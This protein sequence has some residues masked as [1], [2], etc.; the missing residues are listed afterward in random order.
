MAPRPNPVI[1]PGNVHLDVAPTK[2]FTGRAG[3]QRIRGADRNEPDKIR[4]AFS[5][6]AVDAIILAADIQVGL[7]A[8]SDR[9]LC[10]LQLM[11][12]VTPK[13]ME[14]VYV[15]IKGG[16]TRVIWANDILDKLFLDGHSQK[17][18]LVHNNAPWM[19]QPGAANRAELF[20][21]NT[22]DGHFKNTALDTPGGSDPSWVV[23]SHPDPLFNGEK[24][25]MW[26]ITRRDEFM[27][28]AVFIH[29]SG[30]R[31]PIALA[32]W[33]SSHSYRF[34]WRKPKNG[35]ESPDVRFGR[36]AITMSGPVT[37]N[38]ADLAPHVAKIKS[39][40]DWIHNHANPQLIDLFAAFGAKSTQRSSSPLD[41]PD[42]EADFFVVEN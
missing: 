20:A 13:E 40:P 41:P 42:L 23:V 10:D 19:T 17:G 8:K 34:F 24:H 6:P 22:T 39:P 21:P 14:V 5:F 11:Q 26:R 32:K 4:Y 25:F 38:P 29:P 30:E 28:F 15:G 12:F 35:D 27:T 16:N 18:D 3:V 2:P 36:S 1:I 31:Q 33:T 37:T 9:A 7:H